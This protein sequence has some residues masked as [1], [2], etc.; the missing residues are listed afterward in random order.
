MIIFA[1]RNAVIKNAVILKIVLWL[2]MQSVAVEYAVIK[3]LVK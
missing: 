2:E 1:F 3:K